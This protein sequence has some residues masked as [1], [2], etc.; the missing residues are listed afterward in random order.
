MNRTKLG[1]KENKELVCEILLKSAQMFY[2]TSVVW[3]ELG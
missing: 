1:E 2:T 3:K